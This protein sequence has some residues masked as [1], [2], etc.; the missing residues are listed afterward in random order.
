MI[1][2]KN[3]Y[4]PARCCLHHA[5][6]HADSHPSTTRMPSVSPHFLF[7]LSL[8]RADFFCAK[9]TNCYELKASVY[10]IFFFF[11]THLREDL[12]QIGVYM[13]YHRIWRERERGKKV[14][15]VDRTFCFTWIPADRLDGLL[16]FRW[17]H[18]SILDR[19]QPDASALLVRPRFPLDD[20]FPLLYLCSRSGKITITRDNCWTPAHY[21][22]GSIIVCNPFPSKP[23]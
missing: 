6:R 19:Q 3:I 22:I 17:E 10:M 5:R 18:R 2:R 12:C 14:E 13:T 1:F 23:K 15:K 21:Y 7:S 4:T 8:S 9:G 16:K 20:R 11:G